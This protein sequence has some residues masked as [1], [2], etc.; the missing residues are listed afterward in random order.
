[1]K[2]LFDS[3]HPFAFITILFWAPTFVLSRILADWFSPA[4]LGFLR[5]GLAAVILTT[6]LAVRK[7]KLPDPK[8]FPALLVASAFG[9]SVYMLV[10]NHGTAMVNAATSSVT[11]AS[12]PV[13][14]GVLASI[15]FRER[16]KKIQWL[17]LLIEFCGV[18]ILL[19]VG[20]TFTFNEGVLWLLLCA[21]MLSVYNILQRG[22]TKKYPAFTVSA[23][24]IILGGI[25]LTPAAPG[26]FRQLSAAPGLMKFY[27]IFLGIFASAIA[28]VTWTIAFSK[29]EKTSEV[30]NYMFVTPFFA[31]MLGFLLNHEVPTVATAIG[32]LTILTGAIL[33]NKYNK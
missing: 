15:I 31:T 17:A 27:V 1:M 16:L 28:Y 5:Y 13:F 33:F 6:I 30:S 29:A 14:T 24:S 23:V 18:L 3:P 25:E 22:L 8:D 7:T 21:I 4:A 26:A 10:F 32:G 2:K 19:L 12:T 20:S 9:F 11:I